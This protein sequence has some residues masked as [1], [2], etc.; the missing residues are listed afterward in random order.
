[1]YSWNGGSYSMS[2]EFDNASAGSYTIVIRDSKGC[3]SK[4][5]YY[6]DQPM[7]LVSRIV[8]DSNA[9]CFGRSDGGASVDT[10]FGGVSPYRFVWSRGSNRYFGAVINRVRAGKYYLAVTDNN[11]C[12][13]D[14]SV[15]IDEPSKIQAQVQVQVPI[16]CFDSLATVSVRQVTGGSPYSF[17]NGYFYYWD[18]EKVNTAPVRKDLKAGM[19]SVEIVDS[20]E[21][22]ELLYVDLKQP[23]AISFQ[24]DSTRDVR[25]FGERNGSAYVAISGGKPTYK[26]SWF[27]SA[28]T[29]VS[30]NNILLGMPAG[31]YKLAVKDAWDCP[32]TMVQIVKILQPP[33]LQLFNTIN[34]PV[35]CEN[36]SD[37]SLTVEATGGNGGYTYRWIQ[38]PTDIIDST[39]R[40]LRK[41]R[42]YLN[43]KDLLGCKIDTFFDINERPKN[44]IVFAKDSFNTCEGDTITLKGLVKEGVSYKWIFTGNNTDFGWSNTGEL[45][46][47]NIK[48]NQTGFYDLY[49]VDRFGCDETGR[50]FLRV[51]TNPVLRVTSNPKIACLG[52][53]VSLSATGANTYRWFRSRIIPTFGFD[54]VGYNK[55]YTI[56]TTQ[57]KDT[58]IYY[59]LGLS[60]YGCAAVGNYRLKVGLDSIIVDG[61][62]EI[63]EE[64]WSK[65]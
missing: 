4:G 32:D 34:E 30:K 11:G 10:V 6:F 46:L 29:L 50:I 39:L 57:R 1:M 26:Y 49:S 42:Y 54:T 63:C 20:N 64:S 36:Q 23:E 65:A 40:N 53:P 43:V 9:S 5:K 14:D 21:C 25:C 7:P 28:G 3:E 47:D 35:N 51:D 33:L 58:G 41:D 45:F 22:S 61:D 52:S 2:N 16:I 19:H 60:E 8:K 59:V 56:D 37:G 27:N 13:T 48:R 55:I 31:E 15:R 12:V 62:K 24:L 18:L 38:T 17:G 44:P